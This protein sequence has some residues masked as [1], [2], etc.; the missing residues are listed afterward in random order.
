MLFS[1]KK[2][3][4]EW[5]AEISICEN[6]IEVYIENIKGTADKYCY[7]LYDINNAV[8]EKSKWT[9]TPNYIFEIDKEGAY[10]VKIFKRDLSSKTSMST[11]YVDYYN[12]CTK[13]DFERFCQEN[14]EYVFTS[15]L[16]S[17]FLYKMKAPYKDFAV[18]VS[19]RTETI[20]ND[21]LVDYGFRRKDVEMGNL[22]I[23][24][25]AENTDNYVQKEIIFSGLG[26]CNHKLI[27][28]EKDL[29][30]SKDISDEVIGNFT[31]VK[32]EK[33]VLEIGNDYFG[34]GKI[35][36]YMKGELSVITN[37]YHFLLLILKHLGIII[38]PNTKLI[39]ALLCKSR[40]A[41]QQSITREREMLDVYMLPADKLFKINKNGV[42]IEDKSIASVFRLKK[43]EEIDD[44][45][46]I[47]GKREII[48]NTE[49]VLADTRYEKVIVDL[50]G[51]LDSRLVYGAISNLD[52]YRN[53]I[54]I[55]ADGRDAS[56]NEENSDLS[57]AVKVNCIKEYD[58]NTV[59]ESQ[60]WRDIDIVENEMVSQSVLSGYYYPHSYLKM[61]ISKIDFVPAFE[62]NGFYGEICCRPYYTRKLLKEKTKYEDIDALISAIANRIGILSGSTYNELKNKLKEE[63]QYLP[64]ESYLEKWENHYLFYRNGLHCNTIWE[65]E[66]RAP[67]WGPLQSKALFK[68]KHITYGKI[69]GAKEQLQ[70]IQQ[71]DPRLNAV[72]LADIQ[73]ENERRKFTKDNMEHIDVCTMEKVEKEKCRWEKRRMERRKNIKI[74]VEEGEDYNKI[75]KKG[76]IYDQLIDE[77]INEILHKLMKYEHGTFKDVFGLAVFKAIREKMYSLNE[78]KILYQKL[79]SVYTQIEIFAK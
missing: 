7:Y 31:Y 15:H 44:G 61:V 72:P 60:L 25:L 71:M 70:I 65:Y 48:E 17:N 66:K 13:A 1:K 29:Q 58:Y 33:N 32:K 11:A 73:D 49:I 54:V 78:R 67:Q 2:T 3:D 50:T 24:L 64:G 46:L 6:R 63:L 62:L 28:G 27:N 77:K 79:V 53:K 76:E 42:F 20:S 8:V 51:G 52:N 18:V 23:D 19:R 59:Y 5:N 34:T 55:H 38:K 22:S 68:Y 74:C 69:D 21:F 47:E 10:F 75:S 4:R 26:K 30:C 43:T 36:Y 35:Y 40:Q 14:R 39:A 12:K 9:S 37:N 57:I 41:F 45:L 16:K 56:I